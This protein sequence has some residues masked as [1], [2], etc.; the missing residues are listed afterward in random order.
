M[1]K[2][3]GII[4]KIQHSGAILLVDVDVDGQN[5]SAMLIE[6]A[7]RPEWLETG[8]NIEL[9]FK[10]TEVS[11]AKNLSGI[12]SMRNRMKCT[13]KHVER[14]EL[15]SKIS[16]RFLKYTITSAITTRSVDSLDLK[17]GDETEA[18]V[19]ANEVSLMKKQ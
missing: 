8:H 11:L 17:V 6:S 12:I 14:G 16:L 15:L 3:S 1:N 5:F 7:T 4:S 19:K 2:L 18:L 10:E 9:V 13:V